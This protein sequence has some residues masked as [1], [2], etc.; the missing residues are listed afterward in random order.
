VAEAGAGGGTSAAFFA[1]ISPDG[2]K[3][4]YAGGLAATT[5]ICTGGSSCFLSQLVAAGVS[6]ASDNAGNAYIAGNKNGTGLPATPGPFRTHG[7]GAFVAKLNASGTGLAYLTFLGGL[8]GLPSL[9]QPGST[10]RAIAADA[11]DNVYIA[12]TTMDP[13]LPV[14]AS[15]F[16]T[17]FLG[18]DAFVAK[19][20]PTGSALVWA[21]F[22]GGTGYH[23]AVDIAVD[24]ATNVWVSGTTQSTDFPASSGFPGGQEFLAEL[25]P[26][27]SAV[28]YGTRFAANSIAGALALDPGGVIHAAGGTGLVSAITPSQALAARLFGVANAAGA[29]LTGRVAP[30]ELISIYGFHF[31]LSFP[32]PGAFNPPGF[33]PRLSEASRYRSMVSPRRYFMFPIRR[34]TQWYPS[35]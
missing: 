12:G 34:S 17:K 11:A 4:L 15:A 28:L 21:T 3:L 20:N 10:A 30:G 18:A 8:V 35:N 31:G 29:N 16:Q 26:T 19:L 1:E 13:S 27:G 14:T 25:N 9:Q 23:Q 2:D 5:R 24:A 33:C 6:I 7:I 22:L 32:V